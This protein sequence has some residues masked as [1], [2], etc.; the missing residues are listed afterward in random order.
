MNLNDLRKNSLSPSG[1]VYVTVQMSLCAVCSRQYAAGVER[2]PFS[3][4]HYY[5]RV[6]AELLDLVADDAVK[7]LARGNWHRRR[8]R[9]GQRDSLGC[10]LQLSLQQKERW[11]WLAAYLPAACL[12]VGV[13]SS[14]ADHLHLHSPRS[15]YPYAHIGGSLVAVIADPDVAHE[16]LPKIYIPEGPTNGSN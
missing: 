10:G 11:V 16:P 5:T 14:D 9:V 13:F 4:A 3:G 2:G 8:A 6:L 7:A 1:V 15:T 12:G